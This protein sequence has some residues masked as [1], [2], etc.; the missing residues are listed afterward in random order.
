MDCCYQLDLWS[1]GFLDSLTRIQFYMIIEDNA[2]NASAL[3]LP[4][5]QMARS[6]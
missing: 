2:G 5:V 4:R 6:M 3:G 1:M